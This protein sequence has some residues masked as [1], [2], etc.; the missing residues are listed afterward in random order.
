MKYLFSTLC[1][2]SS[3]AIADT[4]VVMTDIGNGSSSF[5]VEVHNF[6]TCIS[7]A[8][9]IYTYEKNNMHGYCISR[10]GTTKP[11]FCTAERI[12]SVLDRNFKF[13]CR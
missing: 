12:G 9:K 3:T 1:L 8:T 2:I 13:N 5:S 6:D 10:D 11:F 7:T 4:L